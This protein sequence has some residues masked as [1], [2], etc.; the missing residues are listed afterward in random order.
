MLLQNS[1]SMAPGVVVSSDLERETA[2]SVWVSATVLVVVML[3]AVE[4]SAAAPPSGKRLAELEAML[5]PHP[6]VT[7]RPI[8]DR[9]AWGALARSRAYRTHVARCEK[10]LAAP[11]PAL[12]DELYLDF[13][14]TGNRTRYQT[15]FGGR[16][17]NLS[18]LALAEC[19][20][21]AGRFLPKIVEYVD[22]ICDEKT[23]VMPAHD[24]KL[25]NFRGE[26]IE[27][28]LAAAQLAWD[29]AAIEAVLGEKLP[30]ATR[31]R[32]RAEVGR[33]VLTPYR[34]MV[35]EGKPCGWWVRCTNNWNAVCHA[36][37]IGAA[38]TMLDDPAERAVFLAGVE[39]NLPYFYKGFTPDGYCSEGVGYWNYGVGHYLMLAEA[40]CR[41]TRGR[42]DL[43][44]GN[45][46]VPAFLRFPVRMQMAAGVYPAF[47][48][49]GVGSKPN[50]RYLNYAMARLGLKRRRRDDPAAARLYEVGV[51]ALPHPHAGTAAEGAASAEAEPLRSWFPDAGVLIARAGAD[52]EMAVAIKG[53]HNAEHHNH[54]DVGSFVVTLGGA[55]PL[56]DPGAE[57]YT[58]RTFSSRRYD[59]DV[60]NSF[61]HPVPRVDGKL[62]STGGRARAKVLAAEFSDTSD[63]PEKPD[64]IALDL[65][66]AYAVK[67]LTTL[68]RTFTFRRTGGGSL[69]V[70]DQV[71]FSAPAAF[72]TALITLG[73]WRRCKDGRL[74]VGEGDTAVHVKIDTGGAAFTLTPTELTAD[75]RTPTKPTRLGIDLKEP[76]R[77]ATI[78]V[79]ITPAK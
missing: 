44:T 29:L 41:A 33:R 75:V 23:W 31:R 36:G 55:T 64:T 42:M 71:A 15:P 43:L 52:G 66:A 21:N 20:E 48:D 59:S 60:L 70:A 68:T 17:A 30:A 65:R 61:G 10:L 11:V 56:L 79:T 50:R 3:L 78:T 6:T 39:A 8:A 47:A 74:L 9:E 16:R 69:T 14:R 25:D 18:R 4:P 38:L 7:G 32:I 34:R 1:R 40:V 45:A 51:F 67:T 63:T 26:V 46:K 76:T 2:M 19:F 12:T 28:D 22:A 62:Q 49:C 37:V 24:R 5:E 27:I 35:T 77:Q 54:N 73:P 53:G 72:G 57:V 58:A 13:S